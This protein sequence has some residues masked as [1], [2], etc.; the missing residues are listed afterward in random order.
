M[1]GANIKI[2]ANSTEFQKQMK[3]VTTQLK[4]IS[5]E[6]SVASTKADLFGNSTDKLAVKQKELTAKISAQNQQIK[7]YQDRIA[8][9]N[10]EITKQKEKQSELSS[11]IELT[12]KQYKESVSTTGKNSEE[13]KKLKEELTNLKE[14][15]AKNEKAINTNNSKLVDATTKMNNTEKAI[16]ENKK[17]LEE[18]DKKIKSAGID[19][20]ADNFEKVGDKATAAGKKMSVVSAGIAAVGTAGVAAFNAVDEGADNA[21][22]ATGAVGE[23][24]DELEDSYKVVAQNVVGDFGSIGSALGE[25]NTRFGYT[26]EELEVCTEKFMRFS[27]VTGSDALTSVQ[28]VSRAMG[29]AGI[30]SSEYS[31]VLDSLALAAQASGISIDKLTENLTK[32]GA[33]MRALGYDTK[34]SIAIFSSWE[35]AGVNTEIAFSGM[36]KAISNFSAEGKDAKVEFAKT[37]EQ[38]KSCPDIAS[39]TTKSI[40]IFGA[41]AGP[42]LADAIKGGRFEFQEM[43][44]LIAGAD[45]TVD[46]TFDGLVDGGYKAELSMQNAKLALSEVGGIILETLAPTF[47]FVTQKLK[48]FSQWFSGLSDAT[49]RTIIIVAGIVGAIGPVLLI[50]GSISNSISKI[51]KMTADIKKAWAGI[52]TAAVAIK[53]FALANPITLII[54]AIVAIIAIIVTLYNKCEWFRDG[55]NAIIT[56]VIGFFKDFN[57]FMTNVFAT[58]WSKHFGLFGN[59]MN[60]FMVTAKGIWD[61]IKRIFGGIIDFVAGVFT[62]DWSRAWEGVKNIFGGIMDGLGAVIKAPLNAVIGL[63]NLAIEGLNTISFTA[64][65]WVP[66]VGGKHFSVNI[67]KMN[68]LY[69]G[70]IIDIPTLIGGNTVIG[71]AYKGSGSQAEVVAPLEPFYK[72]LRNIVKQEQNSQPIVLYSTN[73]IQLNGKEIVRETK[74]EVI[75]DINRGTNNYRR[76]KGGVNYA[77]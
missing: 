19:K 50:I 57:G 49:K 76:S 71:D 5:S 54:I 69:K 33:P 47:D 67:P 4:L 42:D 7:L 23:A 6:C 18:V 29:D 39:A 2:G 68:Y 77:Q 10:N 58:D 26:G 41:K 59:V 17:A 15:Y 52:K 3:E 61:S 48:G 45:G 8:N 66:F 74:K 21:I 22:R 35:K 11:K 16:L 72:N 37:L 30:D 70:G 1:G 32:Y 12:N 25:V 51:I 31:N 53:A 9:I 20:L 64:P 46:N 55:V 34:E 56:G 63:I 44:N 40:E 73:I 75:K 14:E 36:K 60:G 62:G 65:S 28:L 43:L 27:E 24:A 38:I 13:S